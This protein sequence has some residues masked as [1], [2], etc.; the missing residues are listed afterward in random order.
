MQSE[1]ESCLA[2]VTPLSTRY[3]P[4]EQTEHTP[5]PDKGVYEP[6]AQIRQLASETWRDTVRPSSLKYF[7][8]THEV[9]EADAVSTAYLPAAQTLHWLARE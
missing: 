6:A 9:H 1:G 5:V 3:F 4:G 8:K 2:S 7:P